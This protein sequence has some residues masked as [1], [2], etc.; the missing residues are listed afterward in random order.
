MKKPVYIQFEFPL[1]WPA[2]QP[3]TRFPEQG[4]FEVGNEKIIDDLREEIRLLGGSS[5]VISSNARTKSNGEPYA[6]PGVITDFG[7]A[8][9]FRRNGSDVCFACD[10][11]SKIYH[12]IRAI[13]LTIA[14]LRGIERWGGKQLV[15]KAFTGFTALPDPMEVPRAWWEILGVRSDAT[16]D[17]IRR[18]RMALAR[19]FHP[20]NGSTPDEKKMSLINGAADEG[21]RLRAGS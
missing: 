21:L 9:Y 14:A 17:D 1:E 2:Q 6:R 18:A 4:R 7:V 5:V 3:R 20:N 15:D 8:I 11:Y 10:R 12:N 16:T 13:G 19:K